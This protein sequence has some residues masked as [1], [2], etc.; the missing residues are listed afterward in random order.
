ML[1]LQALKNSGTANY[2]CFFLHLYVSIINLYI[3]L[4]YLLL[5]GNALG[6]VRMVRSA[7]MYYCSEAVKYL[8]EFEDIINF[9]DHAGKGVKVSSTEDGN[10]GIDIDERVPNTG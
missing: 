2:T 4:L 6:Y 9:K 10:A 3:F 5:T 8:P 1:H 7:S